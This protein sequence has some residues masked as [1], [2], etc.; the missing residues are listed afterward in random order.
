MQLRDFLSEM[1]FLEPGE[2]QTPPEMK[3]A[4]PRSSYPSSNGLLRE[5]VFLGYL[6]LDGTDFNFWIGQNKTVAKVTTLA[7]NPEID[8]GKERQL[9]CTEVKFYEKIK[10]PVSNQLRVSKVY[11]HDEYRTM[12]LAGAMYILLARHNYTV[13]SDLYQYLPGKELWKKLAVESNSR[14]Y[15]VFIWSQWTNDWIRNQ[16][17]I[18]TRYN[19]VNLYDSEIWHSVNS[20]KTCL[21]ALSKNL[22]IE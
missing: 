19:S 17:S 20:Q 4:Y 1:P 12:W 18:P 3:S 13:V 6:N 2:L 7:K 21:L 11:T 14:N 22:T 16:H 9:V 15:S 8:D 5:F 10:L